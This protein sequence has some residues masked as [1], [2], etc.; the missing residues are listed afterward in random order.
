[1]LKEINHFKSQFF[2]FSYRRVTKIVDRI[3]DESKDTQSKKQIFQSKTNL[4]FSRM[5]IKYHVKN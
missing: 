3:L 4:L 2:S 5:L 1:M